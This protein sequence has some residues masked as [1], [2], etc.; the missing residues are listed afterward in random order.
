MAGIYPTGG[1]LDNEESI[2]TIHSALDLGVTTQTP[3]RS[4]V[5]S[6][7]KR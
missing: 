7:V 6:T 4:M 2:R 5:R 1:G 3:P